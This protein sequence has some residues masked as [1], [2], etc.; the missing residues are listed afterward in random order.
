MPIVINKQIS[1]KDLHDKHE[2]MHG[3][4]FEAPC[5]MKPIPPKKKTKPSKPNKSKLK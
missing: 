2:R 3:R 5:Y 4:G 1:L